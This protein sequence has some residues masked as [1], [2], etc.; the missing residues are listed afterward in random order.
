MTTC[1]TPDE[2]GNSTPEYC[3]IGHHMSI[4]VQ[5]IKY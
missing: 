3:G 4:N 2:T 5:Q 1:L